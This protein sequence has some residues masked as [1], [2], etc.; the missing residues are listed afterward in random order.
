MA[1]P[2]KR[3]KYVWDTRLR[4]TFFERGLRH[5]S[6][7]RDFSTLK[8]ECDKQK[9]YACILTGEGDIWS[10]GG[11]V[12]SRKRC[13]LSFLTPTCAAIVVQMQSLNT[14]ATGEKNMAEG[15]FFPYLIDDIL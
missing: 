11:C 13:N 8:P 10:D 7:N 2:R 6:N 12:R 14:N 3:R 15:R 9:K 5:R 4:Q 1:A